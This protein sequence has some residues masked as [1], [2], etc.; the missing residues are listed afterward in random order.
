MAVRAVVAQWSRFVLPLIGVVLGVAFVSGAL[1]YGAS[2]RAALDRAQPSGIVIEG[3]AMTSALVARIAEAPG[4]QSAR[5]RS[6]GRAFLVGPDGGVVGPPEWAVGADH[7]GDTVRGHA[8]GGPGEVVIDDQTARRTGYDV[9]D[10]VR[11]IVGGVAREARVSGVVAAADPMGGTF[12]AFDPATAHR[13]FGHTAIEVSGAPDTAALVPLLPEDAYIA[14]NA[15]AGDGEKLTAILLGFAAVAV[16]V[17]VFT[18]ANTF[19]MLAAA[20]AREHALLRA[21]GAARRQVMRGVLAEAALL[22]AVATVL[23]H[24]LGIAAAWALDGLFG[25]GDGP[26]VPLRP[27]TPVPVVAAVAVGLGV[28]VAAAYLPARRAAAVPPI[29]ALRTGLPPTTASSRT[30]TAAGAAATVLGSALLFSGSQDLVYLGAPLLF[31]GLVAMV[32]LLAT[33]LTALVR[34]PLTRI[35]GVRGTLAAENTRRNPRRTAATASALMTGLA[36][37]AAVTVPIAS[38]AAKA[39]RDAETGDAADVRITPMDF[40]TAAADLPARVAGLPGARAVTPIVP[41]VLD[42]GDDRVG[43]TGVDPTTIARL[44]PIRVTDGTL[45]LRRG[46]AVSTETAADTGW[47]VGSVASGDVAGA[48]VSLP[49]VAVYD[50]PDGFHHD[51]LV[52][53]AVLPEDRTPT[54]VLVQAEPGQADALKREITAALDNPTMLVRTRAEHRDAEGARFDPFLN[55]LYALLSISVL[56][57]ALGVVNTMTM[58]TIE[59][60]REIGLLRAIGL[61]RRDVVTVL[62]LESVLIALLGALTGLVAGGVVGVAVVLT[63][64]GLPVV[65]PWGRLAGFVA[66]TTV[67][68]LLAAQWPA[69]RAARTPVLTAVGASE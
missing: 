54:T 59:R 7:V 23:G 22:G 66:V 17:A 21:V 29:A 3:E 57:G 42:L 16:F 68:G 36:I 50:A 69:R 12:V 63:Q 5:L 44:V 43:V 32:P 15:A 61:G 31:L 4:V 34:G 14:S 9:G 55:I 47:R 41:A 53:A 58:S 37:C 27:F 60:T 18:V 46:M 26:P 10:V 51:A 40:A 67:I 45:D 33:A 1:L 52:D 35:A 38:V 6:T 39:Q 13:L 30:R 28:T 25:V 65:I 24:P 49:V 2:V 8:P 11:V 19:T 64:G 20:R 48:V 62:R 56:I